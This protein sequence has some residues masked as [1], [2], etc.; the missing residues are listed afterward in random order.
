MARR[1]RAR[2]RREVSSLRTRTSARLRAREALSRAESPTRKRRAP[3]KRPLKTTRGPSFRSR[4][5]ATADRGGSAAGSRLARSLRWDSITFASEGGPGRLL[6]FPPVT[7]ASERG[8]ARKRR[9]VRHRAGTCTTGE[10]CTLC[11][12][13]RERWTSPQDARATLLSPLDLCLATA[14][15]AGARFRA[16]RHRRERR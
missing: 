4:S 11:M 7:F 2:S 6:S 12:T 10:P 16:R 3:K 15:R 14:H 9:S 13:F 5:P 1:P 8:P